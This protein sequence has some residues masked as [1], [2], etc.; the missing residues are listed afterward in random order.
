VSVDLEKT[1]VN[2]FRQ[3]LRGINTYRW[4]AWN[5]AA[6]WCLDHDTNLEEAL[7]WVDRSIRGGYN[8]FAADKNVTNLSTKARILKKLNRAEEM[9]A[10]IQEVDEI[11]YTAYEA[12]TFSIALISIKAYPEV[13][14]FIDNALGKYP[15][16]WYLGLNQGVGYYFMGEEKKAVSTIKAILPKVPEAFQDRIKQITKEMEEGTYKLPPRG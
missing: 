13:V 3:E 9:Q 4:Q 10:T 2:S 15:G 6:R 11:P 7:T 5:D 1:V 8:G 12:N 14:K 16:T